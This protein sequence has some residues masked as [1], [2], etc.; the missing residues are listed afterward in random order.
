MSES[1]PAGSLCVEAIA[2]E[3]LRAG[4]QYNDRVRFLL[5]NQETMEGILK[6]RRER[7]EDPARELRVRARNAEEQRHDMLLDGTRFRKDMTYDEKV[8][9]LM[10]M[11][12]KYQVRMQRR[13]ISRVSGMISSVR[14]GCEGEQPG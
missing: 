9:F 6:R 10:G 4:Q 8:S 5:R 1:L 14:G 12:E 11:V 13:M 2:F 3:M 7:E